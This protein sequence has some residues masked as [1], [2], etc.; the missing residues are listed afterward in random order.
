MTS[1]SFPRLRGKYALPALIDPAEH[2]AYVRAQRGATGLG[3]TAGVIL[4]HQR[5]LMRQALQT[6]DTR[7]LDGWVSAELH[8]VHYRDRDL[9]LCSGFG[10]GAPAAAHVLEQLISLGAQT[11]ITVGTAAALQPD[12]APGTIT[13]CRRAIRDEGL[14]HHYRAPAPYAYPSAA[15]T[16]HL[17]KSLNSTPATVC[18]G[19]TWT[20][21]ALYRETAAELNQYAAEGALTVEMEAA[22]VFTVAA[23]RRIDAAA[24]FCIADSLCDRTPRTESEAIHR[25]LRCLLAAA[26]ST[27][28]ACAAAVTQ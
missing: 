10:H 20:T 5:T 14:S 1:T 17:V 19:D 23:H 16:R 26:L 27:C 9:A 22:G 13:I 7:P 18:E 24:A 15:L 3:H 12:L 8:L 4:I 6:F 25:G 11:V 21:D 2:A 28:I